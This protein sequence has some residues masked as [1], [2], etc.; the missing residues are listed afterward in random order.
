VSVE[1]TA[2]PPR[3]SWAATIT[4]VHVRKYQNICSDSM[5]HDLLS[6]EPNNKGSV[7]LSVC[8]FVCLSICPSV[9][10]SVCPSVC[11]AAL[12]QAQHSTGRH[13]NQ[14]LLQ[15]LACRHTDVLQNAL[16]MFHR[17]CKLWS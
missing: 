13:K 3:I 15:L 14:Q 10:L 16:I 12:L 7:S 6:R 4:L 9:C 5:H 8:L 2:L 17:Y 11:F 1:M